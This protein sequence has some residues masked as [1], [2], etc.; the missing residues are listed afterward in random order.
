MAEATVTRLRCHPREGAAPP[1]SGPPVR[2]PGACRPASQSGQAEHVPGHRVPVPSTC[3]LP[4]REEARRLLPAALHVH[5]RHLHSRPPHGGPAQ[6]RDPRS[7]S[8]RFRCRGPRVP[9]GR[10][11]GTSASVHTARDTPRLGMTALA[12]PPPHVLR[13]CPQGP[14]LPPVRS[15]LSCHVPCSASLHPPPRSRALPACV[16]VTRPESSC[17]HGYL[18]LSG[19]Q[20][21]GLPPGRP[22]QVSA[23]LSGSHAWSGGSGLFWAVAPSA[24]ISAFTAAGLPLW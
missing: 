18:S 22:I 9:L 24:L 20:S 16:T 1:E 2:E 21:P 8:S 19:G 12:V 23:G 15:R 5:A 14:A 7:P 6:L 3:P 4:G 17:V 11:R 10:P 13:G